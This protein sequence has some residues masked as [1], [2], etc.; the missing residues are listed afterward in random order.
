MQHEVSPLCVLDFY[1]HESRQRCGHGKLLFEAMLNV[2]CS[3][4][5]IDTATESIISMAILVIPVRISYITVG[6]EL[7]LTW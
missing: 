5:I 1:V 7:I 6:E 2:S 3:I 4:D